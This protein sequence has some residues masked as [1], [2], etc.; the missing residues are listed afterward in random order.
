MGSERGDGG[1]MGRG[2]LR[3]MGTWGREGGGKKVTEG[4]KFG[5]EVEEK[6]YVYA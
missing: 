4:G 1:K 3:G 2:E 5:V 6:C